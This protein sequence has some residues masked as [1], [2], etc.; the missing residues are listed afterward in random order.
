MKDAILH[1]SS[2]RSPHSPT[3]PIAQAAAAEESGVASPSS[4]GSG[5]KLMSVFG[6][7]EEGNGEKKMG[8]QKAR[9][10]SDSRSIRAA[11]RMII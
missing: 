11:I 7:K 5:H 9:K 2:S 1:P 4:G 6:G 3:T 8:R 10:V